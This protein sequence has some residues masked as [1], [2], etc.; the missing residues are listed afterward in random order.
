M[1]YK[2]PGPAHQALMQKHHELHE[3]FA[4]VLSPVERLAIASQ[5][6]GQLIGELDDVQYGK[7]Q[8]MQVVAGNMQSGNDQSSGENMGGSK[9]LIS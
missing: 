7:Q 2:Q 9:G 8:I 3:R 1:H 6:V 4:D 5:F